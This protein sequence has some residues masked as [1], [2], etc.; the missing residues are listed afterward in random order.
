[1]VCDG[2][3]HTQLN[4][5][6]QHWRR[7]C[8]YMYLWEWFLSMERQE[9]LYG[10]IQCLLDITREEIT[11]NKEQA[12]NLKETTDPF[13][14]CN[15]IKRK[16][17]NKSFSPGIMTAPTTK[18]M[19]TKSPVNSDIVILIG[20]VLSWLPNHDE[21][22]TLFHEIVKY[23]LIL[24]VFLCEILLCVMSTTGTKNQFELNTLIS[25]GKIDPWI[26]SSFFI[27]VYE[28]KF[29]KMVITLSFTK[30]LL[31]YM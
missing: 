5:I 15:R 28:R 8:P 1:M 16:K 13:I 3:N 26:L 27:I 20:S 14:N 21:L 24:S 2:S 29:W 4:S 30:M 23:T 10:K 6:C 18:M 9:K 19:R 12:R 11:Y 17:E 25:V 22:L 31:K 7:W